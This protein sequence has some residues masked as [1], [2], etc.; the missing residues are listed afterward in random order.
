[1]HE[2]Y[3]I[4]IQAETNSATSQLTAI[5]KG[6]YVNGGSANTS[7]IEIAQGTTSTVSNNYV[8]NNAN[9]E[10]PLF[11]AVGGSISGNVLVNNW[12]GV[13]S[14]ADAVSVTS[15]RIFE[16]FWAIE[17]PLWQRFRATALSK[18]PWES[19]SCALL[20]PMCIPTRFRTLQQ[21]LKM[22]LAQLFRPISISV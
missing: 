14:Q 4:G 16:S 10:I 19:S 18:A 21:A 15:N 1:V 11:G 3:S 9:Y 2:F 5:I 12:I 22:S 6:N 20:I 17:P 7:G 13:F 8:L